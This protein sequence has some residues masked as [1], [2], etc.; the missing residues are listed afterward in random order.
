V[1]RQVPLGK[2]MLTLRRAAPRNLLG[3]GM[4]AGLVIQGLRYLKGSPDSC[5]ESTC[6]AF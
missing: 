2:L 6:R 3:A 5:G 4:R 1:P